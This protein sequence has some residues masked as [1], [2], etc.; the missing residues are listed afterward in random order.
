MASKTFLLLALAFAVVLLIT[1]E[2]VSASS[3]VDGRSGYN[4]GGHGG[5]YGGGRGGHGKG[6]GGGY[7]R[8]K[9]GLCCGKRYKVCKCCS[10]FEEAAAY[11]TD[12]V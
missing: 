4:K 10:T 8:C 6:G 3:E 12:D 5:Y 2:V 9:Y 11:K 1:S 7:K